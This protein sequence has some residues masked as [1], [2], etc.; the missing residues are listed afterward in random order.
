MAT[1]SNKFTNTSFQTEITLFSYYISSYASKL[2]LFHNCTYYTKNVWQGTGVW[3]YHDNIPCQR[4][5]SRII[6]YLGLLSCALQNL[7]GTQ[8]K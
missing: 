3:I 6:F 5:V 1:S 7:P 2:P 4:E 8:I